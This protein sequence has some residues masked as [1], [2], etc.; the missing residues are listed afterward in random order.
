[1]ADGWDWFTWGPWSKFQDGLQFTVRSETMDPEHQ[2][3][4]TLEPSSFSFLT[5]DC[6]LSDFLSRVLPW[7][8]SSVRSVREC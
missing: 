7:A 6:K 3:E 2:V 1:M 4:P 5:A 8:R